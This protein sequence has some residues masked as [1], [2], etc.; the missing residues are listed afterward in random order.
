MPR[1]DD[2]SDFDIKELEEA[3]YSEETYDR[4]EGEIPP[5]GTVLKGYISRAFRQWTSEEQPMLMVVF[6]AEDNEGDLEEYNGFEIFEWL[7]IQ[8]NAKWKWAPFFKLFGITVTDFIKKTYAAPE[9]D[10]NFGVPILK[11]G[12]WEVGSDDSWCQV[13]N[14]KKKDNKGEW[15][16]NVDKWLP[17]DAITESDDEDEEPEEEAPPARPTRGRPAAK[18]SSTPAKRSAT[19]RARKPEPEPDDSDADE[20]E[21]EEPEEETRPARRSAASARRSAAPARSAGRTPARRGS[22]RAGDDDEEPPF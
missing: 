6:H 17:F 15:R 19:T 11:I 21:T 10:P 16:G 2:M 7:A 9:D 4:Y 18:A 20:E 13:V 3:E 22:R 5:T 8:A 14:K 1:L 12:K